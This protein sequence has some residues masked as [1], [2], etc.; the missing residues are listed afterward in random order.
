[1][2]LEELIKKYQDGEI[3][4]EDYMS[5]RQVILDAMETPTFLDTKKYRFQIFIQGIFD[6]KGSDV[7]SD[8]FFEEIDNKYVMYINITKNA[9]YF[10][11]EVKQELI[12]LELN[13]I[14]TYCDIYDSIKG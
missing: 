8:P 7:F 6:K 2:E 1:M 10:T 12:T 11:K 4:I 9:K 13:E 5:K 14:S 3:T